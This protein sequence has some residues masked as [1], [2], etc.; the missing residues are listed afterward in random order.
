VGGVVQPGVRDH[1]Y[2]DLV[3]EAS[4]QPVRRLMTLVAGIAVAA[5]TLWALPGIFDF[6]LYMKVLSTPILRVRLD[7]VFGFFTLFIAALGV[8]ALWDIGRAIRWKP[9][10]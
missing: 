8:R 1:I 2:F 6:G 3:Y 5:V 9:D 7:F 10:A 4:P